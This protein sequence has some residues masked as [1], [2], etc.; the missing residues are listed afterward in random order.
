M[1][2]LPAY[3]VPRIQRRGSGD[4]AMSFLK[5]EGNAD[6]AYVNFI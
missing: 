3:Y 1:K 6:L 5:Y 4:R 2:I